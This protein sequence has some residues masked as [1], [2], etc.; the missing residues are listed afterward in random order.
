MI[1]RRTAELLEQLGWTVLND[2]I[3]HDQGKAGMTVLGLNGLKS[4]LEEAQKSPPQFD[5]V[6]IEDTS[7]LSRNFGDLLKLTDVFAR[8][9]V[10]LYFVN[11]KLNSIDPQFRSMLAVYD[12]VDE[13]YVNRLRKNVNDE[14]A[15]PPI[16]PTS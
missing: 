14:G 5:Y 13:Q 2:F 6:V 8:C 7:R 15:L 12:M 10:H 4:L 16:E 3:R 11:E 1:K 9:G